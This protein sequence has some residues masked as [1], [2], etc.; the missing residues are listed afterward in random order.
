VNIDEDMANRILLN[1]GEEILSP[2]DKQNNTL[3]WRVL[4][5]YYLSS[6]L[7]ELAA[8]PWVGALTRKLLEKE[9]PVYQNY[10]P[11][12]FVYKLPIDCARPLE[13][14]G[15]AFFVIEDRRLLAD[16]DNAALL[17]V[18]NGRR[19]VPGPASEDYPDYDD[20]SIDPLFYD[21]LE[22]LIA[23]KMAIKISSSPQTH[24]QLFAEAALAKREAL[25]TIRAFS[26]SRRSG[27]RRWDEYLDNAD[28][29]AL[30]RQAAGQT[31]GQ[32]Q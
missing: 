10:S 17:Y 24:Q 26:G 28:R 14:Q 9:L 19:A 20:L 6:F 23:S 2:L 15:N 30:L 8:N 31:G 13:I 27:E 16:R 12:R 21:Y 11:Y 4:K 1:I 3:K 18:A 5:Q 32:G 22:K 29:E 25:N 7:A